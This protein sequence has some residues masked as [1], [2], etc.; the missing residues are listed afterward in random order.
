MYIGHIKK[1]ESGDEFL[2][3]DLEEHIQGTLALAEK[4]ANSFNAGEW[5]R[6]C[7]LFHDF[8][9]YNP[10]FQKYLKIASG[11]MNGPMIGKIDHKSYGAIHLNT[12]LRHKQFS[13]VFGYCIAGHHSG[14]DNSGDLHARYNNQELTEIY[15]QISYMAPAYNFD[16]KE[17]ARCVHV[18]IPEQQIHHWV[19]MLYSCLVD[20]DW[21]DTESFMKP[22]NSKQRGNYKTLEDIKI[23]FQKHI[24]SFK[25]KVSPSP[26]NQ[27]RSAIQNECIEHATH[28][29]GLYSLTIP[30]GAGKTL[31][32]LA[33]AVNHVTKHN[34]SRIIVV[35]PYTSIITQT[36]NIFRNIFGEE[37][38]IEHHSNIETDKQSW[39][40]KLATENWDAPIILTTNVQFFE[41]LYASTPSK[42]RK[43]HN[44]CNAAII[45]DE[46]QMFPE[47]FLL[48]V[49]HGI[50]AL[51]KVFG[52]SILF[53]SATQPPFT[54]IIGTGRE[55][56]TGFAEEIQSITSK[57]PLMF[58]VFKRVEIEWPETNTR[59]TYDEL[60]EELIQYEQ[61]LCIVNTRQE[62]YELHKRM[63]EDTLHLSR[64]MCTAHIM[65]VIDEIKTR[66]DAGNP[67][68]VISTQLV[69]A[70][71][72]IDFP[73][74]Y[75]AFTGLDSIL[76]SAGRCN[77]EGKLKQLGKVKIFHSEK[78]IPPG[79]QS[80][81]ADTLKDLLL[82]ESF[83]PFDPDSIASYF[84]A[85]YGRLTEFDKANIKH[86]LYD[87]SRDMN[88]EFK[89]AGKA[90]NLIDN[91]GTSF[92]IVYG[93]GEK[94]IESLKKHGPDPGLLRKLQRYSVTLPLFTFKQLADSG[95][96]IQY[97]DVYIYND[98]Y[99]KKQGVI[100]E[101]RF[102]NDI[103]IT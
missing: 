12:I 67:V 59:T 10:G 77:R 17:L 29:K 93:E 14:L 26:I 70:G 73:V 69:E 18:S 98:V 96:I 64:N 99:D 2:I 39:Q 21:L 25:S 74:V 43:L 63:P 30:T 16:L 85:Y 87:N 3:Q 5:G 11:Y 31:S 33:W 84:S 81:K 20:A 103:Y 8:G 57:D 35:I 60:S 90:F 44:I 102:L 101:N 56:F 80:K 76:Q 50:Q 95:R 22:E 41:S 65:D 91:N 83:A 45:F 38:V 68:R 89:T 71:V 61:V 15:N 49:I 7:G 55:Q 37:N 47:E 48:P 86:L 75:R 62:A 40:N 51:R 92:L 58:D 42:C 72:D 66:L 34:M 54:G 1:D 23:L 32:S 24:D 46:A 19:R 52:C 78:R 88:F 97:G 53:T 4:F 9:K 27:I 79:M 100:I 36:A 28:E 13:K 94:L 6:I 82:N